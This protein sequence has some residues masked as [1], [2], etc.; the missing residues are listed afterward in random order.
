[1]HALDFGGGWR[2][3]LHAYHGLGAWATVKP[4]L[5]RLFAQ[6]PELEA[7]TLAS[8]STAEAARLWRLEGDAAAPL[9][10]F[11]AALRGVCNEV[12]RRLL[13]CGDATVAA[14]L[15]RCLW[16]HRHS[17]A[18]AARLVA[19]LVA[20]FPRTF[21]DRHELRGREVHL[22]KKAQLV[23]LAH[24]SRGGR[25]CPVGGGASQRV[26]PLAHRPSY[27]SPPPASALAWPQ[28]VGELHHRFRGE[29]ARFAFADG[30][31]LTAFIARAR[32]SNPAPHL[33]R[34][35]ADAGLPARSQDNVICA[36][37][38]K[39]GVVRVS[40]ALEAAIE[41][42][43]PLPSGSEAEVA[44]RAAAMTG[45]EAVVREVTAAGRG[46]LTPSE[47]GNYLWGGLGKTHAYRSFT[48]HAT[49]D[50][51]FY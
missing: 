7:R 30:H 26:K 34:V 15:A 12:G 8:L 29:D 27:P 25:A 51:V 18:P 3:E 21:D 38:R 22:Y 1:M 44:L 48:R 24:W 42:H 45:V 40:A 50:T 16:R 10:P 19:E 6:T 32:R 37:L 5:Q 14:F 39:E 9:A 49:K 13:D 20:A 43:T 47:L 35:F 33:P 31:R 36:V 41:S 46:P 11:V 2:Q 23:R 28:V 4:G 17:A